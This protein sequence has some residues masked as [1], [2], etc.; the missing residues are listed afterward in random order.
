[1]L[2]VHLTILSLTVLVIIFTDINGLLWVLGK[3]ERL[4][5]NLFTWLHRLVWM[6]L[7]GMIVTGVYM[8]L[9]Y[10]KPLAMQTLFQGKMF[11]VLILLINAFL[12]GKHMSLA[13]ENSF[14]EL[15]KKEK[16]KL[17]LSGAI[18]TGSWI[19]AFTLAKILF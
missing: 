17:F 9:P 2:T 7:L 3:K 13:F 4:P 1:M 18:S 12:I 15:S 19:C 5:R 6:G 16:I 10:L 11:F 8:A 14:S